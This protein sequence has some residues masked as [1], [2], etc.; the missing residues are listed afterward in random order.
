MEEC[1]T[2]HYLKHCLYFAAGKLTRLMNRWAEEE[3]ARCGL[4]P[5]AAYAVL[6]LNDRPNINQQEL[7]GILSIDQSTMTRFLDKLEAKGLVARRREGRNTLL[8]TTEAGRALA[9]EIS[10]SWQQ[11]WKRYGDL[12]GMEA[13]NDLAE[14]IYQASVV[15]ERE[16]SEV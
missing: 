15:L 12:L 16:D 14:R 4:S 9:P 8:E 7:A 6:V 11:L 3:F 1:R 10:A 5:S 13:G 2:E